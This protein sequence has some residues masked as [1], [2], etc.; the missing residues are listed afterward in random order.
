MLFGLIRLFITLVCATALVLLLKRKHVQLNLKRIIYLCIGA[1]VFF[2]VLVFFVPFENI[3]IS[4]PSPEAIWRYMWED[5]DY[6]T[7]INGND[8][9]LFIYGTQD[10]ATSYY[11]FIKTENGWK[12]GSAS[13]DKTQFIT[14]KNCT[15]ILCKQKKSKECFVIVDERILIGHDAP[16]KISDNIGSEFTKLNLYSNTEH[17]E[18]NTYYAIVP[19]Q[20][21][22]YEL[23]YG[24]DTIVLNVS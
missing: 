16:Q 12:L 13:F 10:G 8:S 14:F 1:S 17:V 7:Y 5:D 20:T 21:E 3:F 6:I 22:R 4:F 24:E 2:F 19:A 9:T 15:I 18:I 11:Q 23:S